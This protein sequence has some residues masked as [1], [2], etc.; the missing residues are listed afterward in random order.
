MTFCMP[1]RRSPTELTPQM[2]RGA[3]LPPRPPLFTISDERLPSLGMKGLVRMSKSGGGLRANLNMVVRSGIE[4]LTPSFSN[5]CSTWLSY[6]TVMRKER[7]MRSG[8][9]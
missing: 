4:P 2:G 1:S 6:H 5:S 7:K 3:L 9:A 8:G